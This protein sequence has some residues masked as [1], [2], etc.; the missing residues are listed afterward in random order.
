MV[1]SVEGFELQALMT[2]SMPRPR[3][4]N[5]F[6]L[7]WMLENDWIVS[8]VSVVKKRY[9]K[10]H[11]QLLKTKVQQIFVTYALFGNISTP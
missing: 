7:L 10:G 5:F 9:E 11:K 4:D 1:Y 3:I 6:I 2:A 8:C